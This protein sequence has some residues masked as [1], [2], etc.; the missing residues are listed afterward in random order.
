MVKYFLPPF[1]AVL[2]T[3]VPFIYKYFEQEETRWLKKSQA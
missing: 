2:K 1:S 3:R